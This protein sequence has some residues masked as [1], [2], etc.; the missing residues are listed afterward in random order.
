MAFT[1]AYGNAMVVMTTNVLQSVNSSYPANQQVAKYA[2]V[3]AN[4]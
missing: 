2:Y 1:V 4:L 3:T